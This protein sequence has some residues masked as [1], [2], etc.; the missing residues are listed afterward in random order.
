MS[1]KKAKL[2]EFMIGKQLKE[3]YSLWP[4]VVTCGTALSMLLFT[5]IRT[6]VKSPDIKINKRDPHAPYEYLQTPDG[7]FKQYKLYSRINYSQFEDDPE[8]PKLN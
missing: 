2:I 4:I 6:L 5:A 7:H 3:N 8:K 1:L